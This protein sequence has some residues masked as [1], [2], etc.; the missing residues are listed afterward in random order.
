M[1]FKAI[2]FSN[3]IFDPLFFT[4][5]R[6]D[7]EPLIKKEFFYFDESAEAAALMSNADRASVAEFDSR[8]S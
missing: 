8:Y 6:D 3:S 1:D 2:P 7:F 5:T 4:V